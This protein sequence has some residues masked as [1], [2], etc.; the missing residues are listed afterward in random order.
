M[1]KKNFVCIRLTESSKM[2]FKKTVGYMCHDIRATRPGYLRDD[3][4]AKCYWFP[5]KS[6]GAWKMNVEPPSVKEVKDHL[7]KLRA[8]MK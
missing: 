2:S 6:D 4:D 1:E 8:D 3:P 7:N 5:Q